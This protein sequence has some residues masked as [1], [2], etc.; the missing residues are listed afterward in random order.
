MSLNFIVYE[1]L[2]VSILYIYFAANATEYTVSASDYQFKGKVGETYI[3]YVRAAV[4]PHHNSKS[5]SSSS[6]NA[7]YSHPIKSSVNVSGIATHIK[8]LMLF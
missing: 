1:P 8:C 2:P 6:E 3:F 7:R 5:I 4:Q